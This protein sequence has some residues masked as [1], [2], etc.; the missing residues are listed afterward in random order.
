MSAFVSKE[1]GVRSAR[2]LP[3]QFGA[4]WF[5]AFFHLFGSY[6]RRRTTSQR[7]C[8]SGAKGEAGRR[9]YTEIVVFRV[10]T[11]AEIV[12]FGPL[13]IP[14]KTGRRKIAR[15]N[16]QVRTKHAYPAR[17]NRLSETGV[18]IKTA[19]NCFSSAPTVTHA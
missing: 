17:S 3:T 10:V 16:R 13:G 1:K 8:K 14:K 4:A 19:K 15:R 2:Y 5:D 11:N 9:V 7:H 6:R 18:I 12:S